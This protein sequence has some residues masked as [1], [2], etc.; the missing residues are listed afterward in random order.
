MADLRHLPLIW[1]DP[2]TRTVATSE[3]FGNVGNSLPADP[4]KGKTVMPGRFN[5]GK[6]VPIG[7]GL[8]LLWRV[9]K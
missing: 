3:L 9:L 2:A 8:L 7:V 5:F 4:V 1:D 6:V